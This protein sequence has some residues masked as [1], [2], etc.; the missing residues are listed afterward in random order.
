MIN[1]LNICFVAAI[2]IGII[3]SDDE[4]VRLKVLSYLYTT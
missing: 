2:A 4:E 3:G 1:H